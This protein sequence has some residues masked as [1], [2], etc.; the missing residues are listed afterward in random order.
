MSTALTRKASNIPQ[1]GRNL[2]SEWRILFH[3]F[4]PAS[5]FHYLFRD[6]EGRVYTPGMLSHL[7]KAFEKGIKAAG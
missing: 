7:T 5:F 3:L 2:L 1:L 6:R 4:P